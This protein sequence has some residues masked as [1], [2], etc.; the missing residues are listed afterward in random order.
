VKAVEGRVA[1]WNSCSRIDAVDDWVLGETS[2]LYNSTKP[3]NIPGNQ[4]KDILVEP[5]GEKKKQNH[6]CI[7][8]SGF[9]FPAS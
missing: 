5:E 7:K 4:G 1:V 8:H 6:D 2:N 9:C 3:R